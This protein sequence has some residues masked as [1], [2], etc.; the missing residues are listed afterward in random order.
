VFVA[1]ESI[2]PTV[3][4]KF[5]TY[6]ITSPNGA[7]VKS[8]EHLGSIET[9]GLGAGLYQVQFSDGL[10]SSHT[11][12]LAP[13]G[14]G[15]RDWFLVDQRS[16]GTVDFFLSDSIDVSSPFYVALETE[17]GA[18]NTG[19]YSYGR[20]LRFTLAEGVN[21]I[22]GFAASGQFTLTAT[23]AN[24]A[25]VAVEGLGIGVDESV[26]LPAN[27]A[28]ETFSVM[29]PD[30]VLETSGDYFGSI[31]TFGLDAG[32]YHVQFADGTASSHTMLLA[33]SGEGGEGWYLVDQRS[34]GT[35]DFFLSDNVDV[36][37]P[38][39]VAL[40]TETG[41]GNSSYYSYGR[42]LRFTLAEGVNTI[43]GF[44]ASGQF[45]LTATVENGA[46]VAVEGL[47]LGSDET[48]QL[49]SNLA[50]QAY[51]VMSLDG[52]VAKSGD[53]HGSIETS[54]LHEGLYQVEFSDGSSS[55]HTMLLAPSGDGT[56]DWFLVDQRSDGTVDFFLSDSVD[57]SSPFYVALETE[58][59]AGNT[60]YYSY[61]H[62]LR[63]TLAEGVNTIVGYATSGQFSLTVK[64]ANGTVVSV[65]E[66]PFVSSETISL[67]SVLP[68]GF[69][70]IAT[71]ADDIVTSG[72]YKDGIET[73]GL[74]AG[75]YRVHLRSE[76][77]DPVSVLL[78]N[79]GDE[80][81]GWF[82]IEERPDGSVN[83]VLSDKVDVSAPFYVSLETS[84]ITA[85]EAFYSY[86]RLMNFTLQ[87]G[88]NTI[89]ANVNGVLIS[90]EVISKAGQVVSLA[91][92]DVVDP[93]SWLDVVTHAA[94]KIGPIDDADPSLDFSFFYD[95]A[96]K[97]IVQL[98]DGVTNNVG[99]YLTTKGTLSVDVGEGEFAWRAF[100][101][102][103][104]LELTQSTLNYFQSVQSGWQDITVHSEDRKV[105]YILGSQPDRVA[106]IDDLHL[107]YPSDALFLP[108]GSF[109]VTNTLGGN[110]WRVFQDGSTTRVAG[111]LTSGYSGEEGVGSD[112]ALNAPVRMFVNSQ[113]TVLFSDSANNLIRELNFETGYVRTLWG[114]Q[115]S[116]E[117][118]LKDGALIS[119]GEVQD[120][121]RDYR[122][123]LF[124]TA[125]HYFNDGYTLTDGAQVL[126][127]S[128]DGSWA[129]WYF[130]KSS[131]ANEVTVVDAI[132]DENFVYLLIHDGIAQK[133][134]YQKFSS[135]GQ[136]V[137]SL[138]LGAA[139]G[140]GLVVDPLSGHHLVGDHVSVLK[141]D[142]D[143]GDQEP[144]ALN[145]S[146]ANVSFMS[147]ADSTLV[148]TD[149]DAGR[150]YAFDLTDNTLIGNYGAQIGSS[151]TIVDL[152]VFDGR[153]FA[154]D[155]QSPR[156]LEFTDSGIEVIAGNGANTY[157][158]G[159]GPLSP[160]YYPNA[161]SI[162]AA[163]DIYVVEGNNR[164][165]KFG[166]TGSSEVFA[167]S[168]EAGD[169][170]VGGMRTEARFQSIYDIEATNDGRL[171]VA[172]SFNHTIK[173]IGAEGIVSIL[174]GDGSQGASL[175]HNAKLNTP[176]RVLETEAGR[177]FIADSWNN[178]IVE[179]STEAGIVSFA[180]VQIHGSYQ[181]QGAFAGDLGQATDAYL[182]TPL[183]MAYYEG[184]G[185]L[186]FADSFNHRV[187][188]VDAGGKI[189]TL[190][191]AE[192]GYAFGELLNMPADVAILDNTL[193]IADAGNSLLLE[194]KDFDRT[195]DSI[196][197]ALQMRN[198]DA[199]IVGTA[200]AEHVSVDDVDFFDFR[201]FDRAQHVTIRIADDA[202]DH[203]NLGFFDE[204]GV[205]MRAASVNEGQG[206][207]IALGDFSYLSVHG[208]DAD[209]TIEWY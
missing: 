176:L 55:S 59:G 84:Q 146:F 166:Q 97:Y 50:F 158:S 101:V 167:G 94:I 179:Y 19:F 4:P 189:H 41:A 113:S 80:A 186:Y 165:L 49:P 144:V 159:G 29:S 53:F 30:G 109:L 123:N 202:Q 99:S 112:V 85:N 42:Q 75:V 196:E 147:V 195:G 169:S 191:G 170:G 5:Q 78:A 57:V 200:R 95:G 1:S 25:L 100:A 206:F 71:L 171:L 162:N 177:I 138:E 90:L 17:T 37:S 198:L 126:R 111:G 104:T 26:P 44:A 110:I 27:F 207:A 116:R 21:K 92:K 132:I 32:L 22:M 12:L 3:H 121:G 33:P 24:G 107:N 86:G 46:L 128:D 8:R 172:D 193:F 54:G 137:F 61:G 181:G 45:T 114:E 155:N 209:Y 160:L 15:G 125:D 67:A 108:D 70:E 79:Y 6:S 64:V 52:T 93:S 51:A 13:S 16:D 81:V 72:V 178:R 129:R 40:E 152:E 135:T 73:S 47:G 34:D 133:K 127:Q 174:A 184:D 62:Q 187:R 117:V 161:M 131:F 120:I 157:Y 185:T 56:R 150:V 145:T 69:Y 35:V 20:Q 205:L 204:T 173:V 89:S 151:D 77:G 58:T 154:V 156:I 130:D 149:S 68:N 105:D 106:S 124:V 23:V 201:A 119:V 28:F 188:Y 39:Y 38:F 43:V 182:N 96:E 60:G 164:I 91:G 36:S 194:V 98:R 163:G 11:M 2:F 197:G 65:E 199:A 76:T 14:E 134:Y 18:G 10:A 208:I 87:D 115:G 175:G 63:F 192:S 140:G 203:V 190:M 168:I 102:P 148:I 88:V 9:S 103:E 143:T 180:G 82:T 142:P 83:V 122:G 31:E 136:Q 183:G 118:G 74:D 141:I 48:V 66:V 139:F 7:V 153:L